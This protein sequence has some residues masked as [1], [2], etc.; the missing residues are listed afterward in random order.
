MRCPSLLGN[1]LAGDVSHKK[2]SLCKEASPNCRAPGAVWFCL[3]PL[4]LLK[5][6][7]W[8]R[9]SLIFLFP[10]V[11]LYVCFSVFLC[12]A[13]EWEI[14][15]VRRGG[16]MCFGWL[17]TVVSPQWAT[18]PF[19]QRPSH[20]LSLRLKVMRLALKHEICTQPHWSSDLVLLTY[21]CWYTQI[22]FTN[23]PGNM[24]SLKWD[25][26]FS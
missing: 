4:V 21:Y 11:I 22:L 13:T 24:L 15:Q 12:I 8:Y 23:C 7:S 16:L 2:F 5:M 6:L 9:I 1:P 10:V 3:S 18:S 14:P 25:A 17:S 20:I 19:Q 26:L